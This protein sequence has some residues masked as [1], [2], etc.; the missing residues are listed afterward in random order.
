[1]ARTRKIPVTMATQHPDNACP[2]YFN[3]KR[4]MSA[5][6]EI[7]ECYRCFSELDVDEYMWDWEGKFVDEAVMDR[8]YNQYHDFF[9]KNQIGRDVF[10]TFR[11]P[12]IWLE[13]SHKLPRSFMN[14]ITA[15]A[16]AKTYEFHSPP[17]FEVILPMAESA[18]QLSYLH[19]TFHKISQATEEIFE[20]KSELKMI[21]VIPLF[22]KFEIIA[23]SKAILHEYVD[24]LEKEYNH[25]LD[26]MRVF[27][28]RSDPAM[29]AGLLP[30]KL[31]NKQAISLYHEFGEERGIEMF[32]WVGGG[33]LPFRGGINPENV[34]ATIE[35]HAGVGS[36]T[37]QSAFRYDY[38]L[39]E[40][41]AAI[42]RFNKEIPGRM[43]D[44]VRLS[45]EE[46][47]TLNDFNA[48]VAEFFRATVEQIAGMIN[49]VAG[50]L[51]G[52]RERM[53]HI[54]LFGYSRGIGEVKLPRAIKFTGSL[55]SLGVPP[56]LIGSGRALKLA[57]EM[58][59]L[60]MIHQCCP[61]L[62][63]DFSHAGHYLN[64]ENLELLCGVNDAWK[65][66]RD[67][68]EDIEKILEI[69]I[70]PAKPHH[71]IHRNF[72]STIYHK[73]MLGEDF[74]ADVLDAAEIRK[75]LG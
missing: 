7:E 28:A 2:A 30:A 25:K 68:I 18:E 72:T 32:P 16:A 58:G 27:T 33:A 62:R 3:G 67:E 43:K 20:V 39:E 44:Y 23:N 55:Y 41:K 9:K 35:E 17:L 6:D 56:E 66:V 64:R 13:S 45:D 59:L 19:K 15:E 48:K 69:E 54:G 53:Q 63:K 49:D 4:F 61:N 75:S 22:E 24:F 60:D 36:L 11:V 37:V 5:Q 1:M 26:Y 34:D 52:H 70:G 10:L 71:V 14:M 31:V 21:E 29:N 65:D 8:L 57:K 40:V 47:K 46:N 42:A 38:D 12:N 73:L 50:K 51:P 74:A